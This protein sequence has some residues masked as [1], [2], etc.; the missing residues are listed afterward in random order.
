MWSADPVSTKESEKRKQVS[1]TRQSFLRVSSSQNADKCRWRQ[2]C[3]CLCH[4]N[5]CQCH[6]H[7]SA[8]CQRIVCYQISLSPQ[9][10]S[11]CETLKANPY[12]TGGC[13]L[14]K[15][16]F[17]LFS[18]PSNFFELSCRQDIPKVYITPL[19][20]GR[21]GGSVEVRA[22]G[23]AFVPLPSIPFLVVNSNAR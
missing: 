2:C 11:V 14:L 6:Q 13:P 9:N 16:L 4:R 1:E 5:T 8:R 20:S 23:L 3:S 21:K 19:F 7:V 22:I 15:T 12:R 10:A 18:C 17:S